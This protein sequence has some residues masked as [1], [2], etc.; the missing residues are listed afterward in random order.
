MKFTCN[1]KVINKALNI[2]SKAVTT[3]TTIPIMKGILL[4]ATSDGK[5]TLTA[6]DTY[7]SIETKIDVNCI[8]EGSIVVMSKLFSDIIRKLPVED[9]QFEY[10]DNQLTI[11]CNESEYN[12]TGLSPDEFPKVKIGEDNMKE[13]VLDRELFS[14]MIK[15]TSFAASL[16]DAR[17][18]L[19]GVLME[20]KENSIDLVAID[21]YRF[22]I[23]REDYDCKEEKNVIIPASML[24]ELNKILIETSN[25]D[26][27]VK[28]NLSDKKALFELGTTV[29]VLNILEGEF[30][31]YKDILPKDYKTKITLDREAFMNCIERASLLARE[32]KNNSVRLEIEDGKITIKSSSE[33]GNIKEVMPIAKDGN[34][35]EIGLNSKYIMDVLK[36]ID[37]EEITIMFN[38]SLSPCVIKDDKEAKYEYLILPV[39]INN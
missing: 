28:M 39:R 36:V 1:Q 17:G 31:N 5:L 27:A 8:E 7:M 32:E 15:K 20:I 3:R 33:E 19:T 25:E 18:V 24:N 21:G 11:K 10:N 38:D 13:I 26:Y 35:L 9:I 22:A 37:D 4:N 12:I 6:S 30:I 14:N 29:V 2:V 23:N 16:D 34:S